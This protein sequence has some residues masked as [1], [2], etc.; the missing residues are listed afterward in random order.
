MN[1][2]AKNKSENTVI[3]LIAVTGLSV[4]SQSGLVG[5]LFRV[6]DHNLIPSASS[7][8]LEIPQETIPK[9]EL[10]PRQFNLQEMD[11]RSIEIKG[12]QAYRITEDGD[13]AKLPDGYYKF[14]DSVF[15]TIKDGQII[16][17]KI[18]GSGEN[19]NGEENWSRGMDDGGW[20]EWIRECPEC[21]GMMTPG[22]E[23]KMP[24]RPNVQDTYN[25]IR[26]PE[27]P[28]LKPSMPEPQ[29]KPDPNPYQ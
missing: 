12:N 17:K 26:Q 27:V 3:A 10:Q 25:R 19:F 4:V 6:L 20:G 11:I 15:L 13:R 23:M 21:D 5:E 7:Q 2:N 18:I 9:G 22:E 1:K 8:E 29:P 28:D 14:P 24:E 16:D